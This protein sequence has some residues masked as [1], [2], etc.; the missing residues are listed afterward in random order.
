MALS[1]IAHEIDGLSQLLC[2]R[3]YMAIL[4][5]ETLDLKC[6]KYDGIRSWIKIVKDMMDLEFGSKVLTI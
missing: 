2:F 6:P 5:S 1:I 4:F 3:A